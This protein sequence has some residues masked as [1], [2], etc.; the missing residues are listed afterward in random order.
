MD[1]SYSRGNQQI[2]HQPKVYS[3]DKVA[4]MQIGKGWLLEKGGKQTTGHKYRENV[5]QAM[6]QAREKYI[7]RRKEQGATIA[8]SMMKS[9]NEM[10]HQN[11]RTV[12][13][14]IPD[15]SMKKK[16]SKIGG[17]CVPKMYER[18]FTV[19]EDNF[20]YFVG[21][22]IKTPKKSLLIKG[23]EAFIQTK[24]EFSSIRPGDKKITGNEPWSQ[25]NDFFRVGIRFKDRP[26]GPIYYYT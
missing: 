15:F 18:F 22:E 20:S 17:A 13:P 3:Y 7:K 23:S 6:F 12:H 16:M 11:L 24:S 9:A 1:E 8:A 2:M 5:L 25:P 14:E 21:K 19:D 10:Q 26:A 4:G